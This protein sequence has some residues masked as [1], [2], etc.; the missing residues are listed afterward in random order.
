VSIHFV[1]FCEQV[2]DLVGMLLWTTIRQASYCYVYGYC[3]FSF[4]VL[5]SFGWG[6]SVDSCA[7]FLFWG[8]LYFLTMKGEKVD[9]DNSRDCLSNHIDNNSD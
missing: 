8:N 2:L 9:Y 1:S 3:F 5:G 6:K 7:H 4:A